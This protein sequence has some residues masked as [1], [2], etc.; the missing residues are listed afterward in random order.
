[1][2]GS[3]RRLCALDDLVERHA[4]N[5]Q[6]TVCFIVVSDPLDGF[7]SRSWFLHVSSPPRQ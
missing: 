3:D 6:L 7:E 4:A 5:E 1:M 2:L